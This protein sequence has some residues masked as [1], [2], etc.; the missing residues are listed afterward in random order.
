MTMAD[1]NRGTATGSGDDGQRITPA[2]ISDRVRQLVGGAGDTVEQV[3]SAAVAVAAA[4]GTGLVLAAF[5]FGRRRGR[6][7]STLVEIVRV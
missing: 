7:R 4:V 5:L 3:S 6:R 1:R 2:D